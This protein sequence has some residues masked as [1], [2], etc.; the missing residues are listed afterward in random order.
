VIAT[1]CYSIARGAQISINDPD[2]V[3]RLAYIDDVVQELLRAVVGREY[4]VGEFCDVPVT[5]SVSLGEIAEKIYSFRDS[6]KNLS[7]PDVS[8]E[9]SKKLYATYLSFLPEDGFAY[10]LEMKTDN[11]GSFTEFMKSD[12]CGQMSVNVIKPG[13]VK[14]QHWHHTKNE[15][16]LVI[17][18]SGVV[19][20]REIHSDRVTEY[21]VSGEKLTVVDIPCGYTHNIEN[22]GC[23]DMAV[24]MWA[25]ER[26]DPDKPDT[27]FLE[28]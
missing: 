7:V 24:L 19:R 6:R 10:E 4:S 9:F 27:Y 5:H 26:F 3:L 23:D 14:G 20:F 12:G 25:S 28:V 17:R 22:L 8:D 15:K 16:F 2:K 13:V 11:R 1:F 18:G 21:F